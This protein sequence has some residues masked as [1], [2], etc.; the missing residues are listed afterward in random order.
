M[1]LIKVAHNYFNISLL[2]FIYIILIMFVCVY[3]H[4]PEV[5]DS[6]GDGHLAGYE[7]LDV[8]VGS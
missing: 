6:P 4:V 7:P 5:L 2:K 3:V 8:D 1:V